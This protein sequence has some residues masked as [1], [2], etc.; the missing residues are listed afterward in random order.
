M[1][2][3]SDTADTIL[4]HENG[5]DILLNISGVPVR[6]EEGRIQ[7]AVI[8]SRDITGRRKLELR[9][10]EALDA[11]VAMT[12]VIGQGFE[13]TDGNEDETHEQTKLDRKSTRLNSR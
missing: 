10:R 4:L 5:T 7:G 6:D 2:T 3:G 1:M 8:V 13:N 11:L 12:Q 9:T